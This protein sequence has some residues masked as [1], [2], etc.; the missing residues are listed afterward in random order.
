MRVILDKCDLC[1]LIKGITPPLEMVTEL[2]NAGLGYYNG[3]F[4]NEWTWIIDP[5]SHSEE[6]LYEWYK[7]IKN[8]KNGLIK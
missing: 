1:N 3:G 2:E 6:D 4:A 5:E 7:L 8:K